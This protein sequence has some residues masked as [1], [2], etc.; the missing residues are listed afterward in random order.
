MQELHDLRRKNSALQMQQFVGEEKNDL[1]DYLR[2]LT[3]E[4]VCSMLTLL[5]TSD[6]TFQLLND[7]TLL[8]IQF[9]NPQN[10]RLISGSLSVQC[11]N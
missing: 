4:K 11:P 1:L 9:S 5:K 2:S 3:P 6:A 7:D 8:V 10:N